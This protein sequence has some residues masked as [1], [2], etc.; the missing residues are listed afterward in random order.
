MINHNQ[1]S[2]AISHALRH[3]PE[4]YNIILDKDG[5]VNLNSLL[6]GLQ[7]NIAEYH[8]LGLDDILNAVNASQKRRHEIKDYMI[9]A[10]YGHST[11][12]EMSYVERIPPD[13]L[14]HGTSENASKLILLEGLKPMQ[15]KYV[16]LSSS[17][18][19]AIE[20]G[21]RKDQNPLLLSIA[22][23][24]AYSSGISFYF[25]NEDTWLTKFVPSKFIK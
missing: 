12:T 14:F 10:I 25:V 3:E 6:E 18:Y 8:N 17:I 24:R 1:L 2:K 23:G 5:W 11:E 13:I 9:R 20:V 21:K 4:K 15:R 16:H 22:T 7:E 19:S